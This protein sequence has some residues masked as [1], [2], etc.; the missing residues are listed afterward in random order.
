MINSHDFLEAY[1]T[2]T[3]A[4]V[5]DMYSA[6]LSYAHGDDNGLDEFG[7][8]LHALKGASGMT[9]LEEMSGLCHQTEDVIAA[10]RAG[11]PRAACA[12][13]LVDFCDFLS[14]HTEALAAG[15]D[16]TPV[17]PELRRAIDD[18]VATAEKRPEGRAP[19]PGLAI[20]MTIRVDDADSLEGREQAI[21]SLHSLRQILPGCAWT[22]DL[23]G[24]ERV[25]PMVLGALWA[26]NDVLC[27]GSG[28]G[29][30]LLRRGAVAEGHLTRL[31]T[32]FE[33]QEAA[34]VESLR[35]ERRREVPKD[36]AREVP[37]N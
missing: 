1:L 27:E 33:V 24:S 36:R 4:R 23:T 20:D 35:L 7:R 19:L 26:L 34:E 14:A 11:A 2:E 28:T 21:A 15:G 6:L 5:E 29:R 22:V 9:G 31:R 32:R 13:V 25:S 16:P 17:P 18:L 8:Q 30:L 10:A 12:E 3:G 37:Q